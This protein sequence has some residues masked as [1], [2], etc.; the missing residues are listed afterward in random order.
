MLAAPCLGQDAVLL[1]TLGEALEG[2]FE[3]FVFTDDYFG[4]ID[5]PIC[6][7]EPPGFFCYRLSV[8]VSNRGRG[9]NQRNET[10]SGAGGEE[11]QRPERSRGRGV[12]PRSTRENPCLTTSLD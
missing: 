10:P 7:R 2:G 8:S 6:A 9:R 4:Q 12:T 3:G 11:A 1:Y 5:L